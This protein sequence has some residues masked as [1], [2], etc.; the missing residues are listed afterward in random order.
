M[1]LDWDDDDEEEEEQKDQNKGE[2]QEKDSGR[3]TPKTSPGFFVATT[4]PPQ[5]PTN[6]P[7][8]SSA[9]GPV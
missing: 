5:L 8:N 6:P 4:L 3:K 2:D 7:S 9:R 1:S